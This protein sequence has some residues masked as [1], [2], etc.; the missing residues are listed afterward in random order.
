MSKRVAELCI[1]ESLFI[2][3]LISQKGELIEDQNKSNL[4]LGINKL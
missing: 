2:N 3:V 1:I 4:A